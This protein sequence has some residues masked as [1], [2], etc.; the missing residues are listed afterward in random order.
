MYG[1]EYIKSILTLTT[2]GTGSGT[3]LIRGIRMELEDGWTES[4]GANPF[5]S[6]LLLYTPASWGLA[7]LI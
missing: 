6:E 3:L 4:I 5:P 1:L 7:Y 2:G